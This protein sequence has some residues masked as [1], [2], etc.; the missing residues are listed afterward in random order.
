MPRQAVLSQEEKQARAQERDRL[1][2]RRRREDGL[3]RSLER[4]RNAL[5]MLRRRREKREARRQL[6]QEAGRPGW[7][8]RPAGEAREQRRQRREEQARALQRELAALVPPRAEQAQEEEWPEP[9]AS[10]IWV[11]AGGAGGSGLEKGTFWRVALP[12][13]RT[14]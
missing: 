7:A 4:Q 11:L 14:G 6:C 1:K 5:A 13:G 9:G 3:R 8:S 12:M 2:K 10:L